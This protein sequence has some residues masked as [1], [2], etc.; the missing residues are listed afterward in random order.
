M[1][2]LTFPTALLAHRDI[3]LAAPFPATWELVRTAPAGGEWNMA[4]DLVLMNRARRT[5]NGVVRLYGWSRPTVS[6][7]RHER[8]IGFFTQHALDEAG[9]RAVRRPTGGRALL[10]DD[11]ITYSVCLPL[12]QTVPWRTAYDA[13]NSLL[14]GVLRSMGVPAEIAGPSQ[15]SY[16]GGPNDG[17][18]CFSGVAPGEIAVR[19]QKL[20]ASAVWRDRGAF[21]Q[22]GSI[23]LADRQADLW[24]M[25]TLNVPQPAPAAVLSDYICDSVPTELGDTLARALGEFGAANSRD[26]DELERARVD[27]L[28]TSLAEPSWLWRR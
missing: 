2:Q 23:L 17:A 8:T 16:A 27:T 24:Q 22:Q 11:E 19:G 25:N 6:F 26:L 28:E 18:L 7:G 9:L 14:A 3:P 5:G 15:A 20:V 4:C 12:D 10:H 1:S 21:L 13:V